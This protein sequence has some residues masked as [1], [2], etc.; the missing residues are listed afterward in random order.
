MTDTGSFLAALDTGDLGQLFARIAS[1]STKFRG[2]QSEP[3]CYAAWQEM[4]ALMTEINDE[5]FA[6]PSMFGYYR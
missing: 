4:R 1:A 5:T 6:R 3:G 2:K